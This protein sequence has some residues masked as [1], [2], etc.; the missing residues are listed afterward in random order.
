VKVAI[1]LIFSHGFPVPPPFIKGLFD[2]YGAVLTGSG[3]RLLPA[4]RAITDARIIYSEDFPVDAARNDVCRVFLDESDHDY[5]VFLDADM[6]HPAETIHRLLG[7]GLPVVT[8]RYQMRRPP[9]HTVAM[10]KTGT[11]P[12]DYTSVAETSGLVPIEAGG[13]GVLAIRRDVLERLRTQT[14]GEWFRYQVGPN[15][16]RSVSEDMWFYQQAILA[17]YQ[18]MAD[19]DLTCSHVASFEVG[20]QWH[21]P[22]REAYDAAMVSA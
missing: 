19:L 16:L 2:W 9:F 8:G 4:E 1:G 12:H 6:R 10:R 15:G 22:F 20:P 11:G 17:G 21:T 5:L 3:N 13:A 7:H 14:N 18:P